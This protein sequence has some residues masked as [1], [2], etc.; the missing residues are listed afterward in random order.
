MRSAAVIVGIDRYAQYPLTS[1]VNDGV[2]FRDA[3]VR[4]GLVAA[5]DTTILT[6]PPVAGGPP[7]VRSNITAALLPFY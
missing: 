2:A 3:L 5:A 4:L 1:C 6:S 7:A